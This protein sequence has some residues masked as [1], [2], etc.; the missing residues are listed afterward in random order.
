MSH[1]TLVII[2]AAAALGPAIMD[3]FSAVKCALVPS[4]CPMGSRHR[5]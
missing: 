2:I 1:A 3:V 4:R 5:R